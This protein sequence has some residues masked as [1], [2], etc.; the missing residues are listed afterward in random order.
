VRPGL[1]IIDPPCLDKLSNLIEAHEPVL[2][3][4][5]I[6]KF[7]IEA[8]HVAIINRFARTNEL[9]L[10]A[11]SI[12]PS[13]YRVADKF[14]P[15]V[16]DDLLRQPMNRRYS[17]QDLSH[18]LTADRCICFDPKAL[19]G[20]GIDD[21]KQPEFASGMQSIMQKIHRPELIRSIRPGKLDATL[22]CTFLSPAYSD[23]KLF[24]SINPLRAFFVNHQALA[25]EK[26]MK[27]T[28]A[29]SLSLL[30]KL[31]YPLAKGFVP[32]WSLFIAQSVPA[33]ANE[34]ADTSLAQ[35]KAAYDIN[36]SF[37]SCLGL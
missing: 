34:V 1:I 12:C 16:H 10:D 11:A 24:F 9:Q 31:F 32:I 25:L 23:S 35:P 33:E 28:A 17:G 15:I 20:V 22:R 37:F 30:G 14:R 13:I 6:P 27:P 36:S 21:R 2:I 7:A 5:F 4:T 18:S 3:K 8:L 29:E 26:Q 19:P